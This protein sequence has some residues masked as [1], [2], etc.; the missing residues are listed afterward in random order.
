[1]PRMTRSPVTPWS[2][3]APTAHARRHG[4]MHGGRR[5]DVRSPTAHACDLHLEV[6][7]GATREIIEITKNI[8]YNAEGGGNATSSG[9]GERGMRGPQSVSSRSCHSPPFDTRAISRVE[10]LLELLAGAAAVVAIGVGSP[11][12]S[13][14]AHGHM[15]REARGAAV[16]AVGAVG[17]VCVFGA[18]LPSSQRASEL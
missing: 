15:R 4:G 11:V 2:A 14:G 7:H 3:T 12:A 5:P 13:L 1:M 9:A 18:G 10:A 6:G 16:R 8:T 17:A